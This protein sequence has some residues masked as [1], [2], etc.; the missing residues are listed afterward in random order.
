MAIVVPKVLEDPTGVTAKPLVVY[1][2]PITR[3]GPELSGSVR[4]RWNSNTLVAQKKTGNNRNCPDLRSAN[5][6]VVG[7]SPTRPT[8]RPQ[9]VR[10]A[11]T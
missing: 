9:Q 1:S 11:K 4:G 3:N 5:P 8:R 6:L 2:T 7:S 10:G